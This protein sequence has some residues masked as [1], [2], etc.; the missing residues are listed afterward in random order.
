[1]DA[2]AKEELGW[3]NESLRCML[4]DAATFVCD[5]HQKQSWL[6]WIRTMKH[7]VSD[8]QEEILRL[9]NVR[10]LRILYIHWQIGVM[11]FISYLTI[12]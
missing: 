2:Y 12:M 6:R 5:F 3:R 4:T 1:M 8:N 7:G 10:Q 11:E 9:L